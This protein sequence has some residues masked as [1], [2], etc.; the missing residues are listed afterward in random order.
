MAG[1]RRAATRRRRQRDRPPHAAIDVDPLEQTITYEL[2]AQR[3]GGGE[4]VEE[5]SHTLTERMYFR[6]EVLSMLEQTGFAEIEVRGGYEDEEPRAG[7]DFLAFIA[8]R[9]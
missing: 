7:H 2:W 1:D 5:E 4:V 3:L 9:D 8:R 6:G